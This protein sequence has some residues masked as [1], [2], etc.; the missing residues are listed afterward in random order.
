M[1]KHRVPKLIRRSMSIGKRSEL[2]RMKWGAA[3]SLGFELWSGC[4]L[5]F[6]QIK[7][8][9]MLLGVIWQIKW[10]KVAKPFT[11]FLGWGRS[12]QLTTPL[13]N[14]SKQCSR[15]NP[16]CL[17]KSEINFCS[18]RLYWSIVSASI[19]AV[20]FQGSLAEQP[21]LLIFLWFLERAHNYCECFI[22]INWRKWQEKSKITGLTRDKRLRGLTQQQ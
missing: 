14:L 6:W 15:L 9:H 3:T 10:N 19:T 5:W 20:T 21:Q 17:L 22:S 8:M 13:S 16:K 11:H 2:K 4:S 18:L 7:W 1:N 12:T